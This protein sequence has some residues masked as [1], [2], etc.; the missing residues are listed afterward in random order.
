MNYS[1][2]EVELI[3]AWHEKRKAFVA[4]KENRESDPEAYETA[5]AEMSAFRSEWRGIREYAAAL[6][7]EDETM[8]IGE[9]DVVAVSPGT[10]GIG[11]EIN[12]GGKTEVEA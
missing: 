2:E 12:G 7:A 9:G 8:E 4:A 11:P 6:A 5:K 3:T 1:D 10:V